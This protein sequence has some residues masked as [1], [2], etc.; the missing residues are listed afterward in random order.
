MF[1][2]FIA[3][4]AILGAI[5]VTP[6]ASSVLLMVGFDLFNMFVGATIASHFFNKGKK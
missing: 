3:I 6:T 1:S 2:L 5:S 4:M